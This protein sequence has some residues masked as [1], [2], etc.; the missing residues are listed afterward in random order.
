M[1]KTM[2]ELPAPKP[3]PLTEEQLLQRARL[4]YTAKYDTIAQGILANLVKN[5]SA[6]ATAI[7]EPDKLVEASFTLAEKFLEG[8][9][10]RGTASF[11]R[12]N[13]KEGK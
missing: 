9:F 4:N 3:Q 12:Y 1:N 7:A 6:L 2:K 11:E 8:V 5:P 10:Q 13:A